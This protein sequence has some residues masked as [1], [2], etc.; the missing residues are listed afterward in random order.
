MS[1]TGNVFP[2]V[3]AN[4]DRAGSTAWTDPGNVVSDN[5][6]DATVVVPSDYLVTSGY[7]FSI[8]TGAVIQGVTVRVEA[9]ETGS[10]TSNYVPQLHSATTPTLIGSAKTAVTVSGATKVIS[11]NGGTSDLWGATLTPAIVNDAGFG[12]S[13]WSADTVNTL[14]VDFVTIAIEYTG[15]FSATGSLTFGGLEISG[16]ATFAMPTFSATGSLTFGGLEVSGTATAALQ[17]A[18]GSGS[19][20]FGGLE[21]TGTATHVAPVFSAAGSVTFAGLEIAGAGA[22]SEP[23]F[24]ATAAI[25]LPSLE[26]VGTGATTAPTFSAAGP[27]ELPALTISGSALASP[28]GQIT[29]TGSLTFA[30][31]EIAGTATVTAPTFAATGAATFAGLDIS[32]TALFSESGGFTSTGTGAI[33]FPPLGIVRPHTFTISVLGPRASA[34]ITAGSAQ[35]SVLGL[36]AQVESQFGNCSAVVKGPHALAVISTAN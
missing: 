25:T 6:T 33:T 21:A 5:T 7:G 28:P 35:G 27:L 11:T 36:A 9:S 12:V 4:V 23:T 29:A 24:T 18:T 34:T 20:T 32:G 31:L 3:G 2:T 10:G 14:A 13:I 26:I 16:A 17:T 22:V 15:P 30:G 19:L 8:P 1:S